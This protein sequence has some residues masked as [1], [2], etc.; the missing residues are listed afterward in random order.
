MTTMFVGH[1][2]ALDNNVGGAG[3]TRDDL[4]KDGYSCEYV[5]TN[6]WECTKDGETTYWCD[7]TGQCIEKPLRVTPTRPWIFQQGQMPNGG[8]V[9]A[10]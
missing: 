5:A 7:S 4:E 10:R 1:A 6:F 9:I 8:A 2:M 3:K